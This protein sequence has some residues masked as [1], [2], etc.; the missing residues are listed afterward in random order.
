MLR[1][2]K[3]LWSLGYKEVDGIEETDGIEKIEQR[4]EPY[5][6]EISPLIKQ[7]RLDTAAGELVAAHVLIGQGRCHASTRRALDE[8]FHD[9]EWLIDFFYGARVLAYGCGNGRYTNRSATELVDDG[10]K[11]LVVYLVKSVT[12]DIQ[13]PERHTGN[14]RGY[15][16]VALHLCKV[17]DSAEQGVGDT[18]RTA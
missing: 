16:A 3:L 11:Y 18:W 6:L 5:N 14:V 15:G 17:T 8:A 10:E 13:C 7:R 1:S 2:D 4:Q 9:E 12:V